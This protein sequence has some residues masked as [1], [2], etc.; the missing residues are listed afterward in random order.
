METQAI[1]RVNKALNKAF[2]ELIKELSPVYKEVA[3]DLNLLPN[4]RKLL[5]VSQIKDLLRVIRPDASRRYDFILISS[6]KKARIL[7]WIC[8]KN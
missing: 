6:L 7:G 3:P 8:H 5:I 2:V 4:Q 1:N